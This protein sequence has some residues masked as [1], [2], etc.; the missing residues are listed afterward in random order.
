MS[1]DVDVEGSVCGR[2]ITG[3]IYLLYIS[4]EEAA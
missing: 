3:E 1:P 2:F 4:E